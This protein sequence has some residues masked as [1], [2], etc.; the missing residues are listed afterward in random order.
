MNSL[1]STRRHVG[2]YRWCDG[3]FHDLLNDVDKE[4][5]REH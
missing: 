3:H 1:Q 4:G 5:V 2:V